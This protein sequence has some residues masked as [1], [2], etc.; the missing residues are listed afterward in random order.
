MQKKFRCL[1][2]LLCLILM[3]GCA[4]VDVEVTPK[5]KLAY[6]YQIYNAQHEDYVSMSKSSNLTDAQ[7]EVLRAKK[8]ILETL[9]TLI[10]IYDQGVQ[11]GTPSRTQEQQIYDLLNQLQAQGG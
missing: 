4:T 3:V 5:Q 8:P 6:M 1:G 7:K 11:S 9:Q 2:V 10:P